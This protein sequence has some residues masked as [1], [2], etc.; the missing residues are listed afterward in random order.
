MI[1][2]GVNNVEK[3]FPWYQKVMLEDWRMEDLKSFGFNIMRLGA[4]W[5]GAEPQMGV[6]NGTYF[7]VSKHYYLQLSIY[8]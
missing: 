3:G 5:T 8:N 7:Q 1:F 6:F 2:R 4:M